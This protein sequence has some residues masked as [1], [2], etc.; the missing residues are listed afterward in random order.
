[1]DTCNLQLEEQIMRHTNLYHVNSHHGPTPADHVWGWGMRGVYILHFCTHGKGFFETE[2]K[3]YEL[4]P[5]QAFLIHPYQLIR[6]GNDPTDPLTYWWVE[7]LGE[8]CEELLKTMGFGQ[9]N[10]VIVFRNPAEIIAAM[11]EMERKQDVSLPGTLERKAELYRLMACFLRNSPQADIAPVKDSQHYFN[12]AEH[13]IRIHL[14]DTELTV[15]ATAEH[16][17][18]SRKYLHAIFV[19]YAGKSVSD[20]IIDARIAMAKEL[21]QLHRLSVSSVAT[22]VGYS[23]PFSFTRI[24]KKRVGMSP[25]QYAQEHKKYG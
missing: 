10:Q 14:S 11:D 2:G 24:F 15:A 1:M 9:E 3:R 18:I 19:Q 16:T 23:D 20:Y 21:L 8:G 5:G 12:V 17:C 25:S 13:Y 4:S 22:S 6:Y 7:W